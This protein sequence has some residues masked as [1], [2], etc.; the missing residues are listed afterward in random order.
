MVDDG[1][2]ADKTSG[3]LIYTWQYQFTKGQP[4]QITYKY[5]IESGD[6]EAASGSN[7]VRFIGSVGSYVMPLDTFGVMFQESPVSTLSIQAAS[8]GG[9]IT[10]A[11]EGRP[12]VH[13]QRATS[14][15]KAAWQDVADTDG[16]SS[17][18]L[19]AEGGTSFFRLVK[20]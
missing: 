16:K 20:P 6:N 11:W 13:L 2:G 1:T 19:T 7:H 5:G 4:T 3:D 8:G 17:I 14:L 10:V 18:T 15:L 9:H 12:G